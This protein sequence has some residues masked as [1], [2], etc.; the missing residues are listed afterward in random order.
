MLLSGTKSLP[1]PILTKSHDAI[2]PEAIQLV[3]YIDLKCSM[4]L[5]KRTIKLPAKFESEWETKP[6]YILITH[7]NSQSW[8]LALGCLFG[9]WKWLE[10]ARSLPTEHMSK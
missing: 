3:F 8:Y 9:Y 1:Q 5:G 7:E 10:A 6:K 4:L 2:W